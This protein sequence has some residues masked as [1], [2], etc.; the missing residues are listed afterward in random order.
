MARA[1]V[2]VLS[3]MFVGLLVFLTVIVAS[4]AGFTVMV[5][6]AIFVVAVLVFGALGSLTER[7]K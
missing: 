2:T 4:R 5:G 3:F 7:R 1:V 6:L